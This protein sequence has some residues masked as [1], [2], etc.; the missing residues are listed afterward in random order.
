MRIGRFLNICI[1]LLG[2]FAVH[3]NAQETL[4]YLEFLAKA[5]K[6]FSSRAAKLDKEFEL[7]TI[8][9]WNY[10]QSEGLLRFSENSV[11]KIAAKAQIVGSYSKASGTW[12]WSWANGTVDE[13]VKRDISKVREFGAER[14]FKELTDAH[15]ACGEAHA[16]TLVAAAG[17]VLNAR[18]AYRGQISDGWVYFLITDVQRVKK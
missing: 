9:Q 15:F 11:L 18:G 12:K 1:L 13:S 8:D 2:S 3:G 10:S 7:A 4:P 14:N 5:E 6:G 16:W 17:E